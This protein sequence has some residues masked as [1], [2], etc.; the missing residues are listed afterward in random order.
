MNE[1]EYPGYSHSENVTLKVVEP[2]FGTGINV[3]GD[4]WFTSCKLVNRLKRE[5]LS[6]VGTVKHNRREI[7]ASAKCKDSRALYSAKYYSSDH[8]MLLSYMDKKTASVTSFES[9]SFG[10]AG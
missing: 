8:T 7:P 6:Y 2:Y 10:L 4:N 3:T 1:E 9:S 5:S